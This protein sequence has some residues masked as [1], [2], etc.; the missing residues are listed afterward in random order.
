MKVQS[1]PLYSKNALSFSKKRAL[2]YGVILDLHSPV[3]RSV[4]IRAPAILRTG[5]GVREL[6]KA[7][8]RAETSL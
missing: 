1:Q 8:T 3:P 4:F 2:S 6:A 7:R 5:S